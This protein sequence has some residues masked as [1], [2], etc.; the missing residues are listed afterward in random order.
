MLKGGKV[1]LVI[2]D[3]LNTNGLAFS[4]DQKILYANGSRDRYVKRYDVLPDDAL[5]NGTT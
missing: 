3:I 1:T 5:S 2:K 4:P